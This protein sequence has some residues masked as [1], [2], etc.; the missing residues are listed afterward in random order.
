VA[1]TERPGSEKKELVQLSLNFQLSVGQIKSRKE[2]YLLYYT[3]RPVIE[4]RNLLSVHRKRIK[5]HQPKHVTMTTT[6]A[7]SYQINRVF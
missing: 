5:T 4:T 7:I 2:W 6:F 3:W 1:C